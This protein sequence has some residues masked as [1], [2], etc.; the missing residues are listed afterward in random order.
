MHGDDFTTAGPKCEID[1]F[2]KL[3]EDKYE[4][5]KGGRPGPGPSD[6]KELT[7]LN[8]VIRWVDGGVEYEADP[9]QGERLVEG[10]GLDLGCKAIATPGLKPILE[11]LVE[12]KLLSA[13][14][15]ITCNYLAQDRPD[16]RFATKEV[17]R[18]VS[19]PTETSEV[20][21]K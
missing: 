21:L 1:W 2:E 10:L 3:L 9:H 16:L 11:K 17:C 4:L 13:D 20:A 15:H 5:K 8:R 7:V 12:G 19:S 6:T 14:A 18:F